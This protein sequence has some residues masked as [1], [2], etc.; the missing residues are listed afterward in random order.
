[1]KWNVFINGHYTPEAVQD[2][3]FPNGCDVLIDKLYSYY[4]D[5]NHNRRYFVHSIEYSN[6]MF[7]INLIIDE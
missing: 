2:D 4:D 5:F 7:K 6:N 3:M 1:M